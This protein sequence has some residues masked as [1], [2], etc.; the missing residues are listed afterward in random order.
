MHVADG[1]SFALHAAILNK[2]HGS[3]HGWFRK[4]AKC[5]RD[6]RKKRQKSSRGRDGD[7]RLGIH[8]NKQEILVYA[9]ICAY[10]CA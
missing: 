8:K 6:G 7:N 4:R 3:G 10:M 1:C 5:E 2:T 9:W